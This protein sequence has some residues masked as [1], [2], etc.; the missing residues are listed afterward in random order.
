M[1]RL[2]QPS[3]SQ[4]YIKLKILYISIVFI[5]I[6]FQ[7]KNLQQTFSKSSE[8]I[9][10]K[11]KVGREAGNWPMKLLVVRS[12]I[13]K[14]L[15]PEKSGKVPEREFVVRLRDWRFLQFMRSGGRIPYKSLKPI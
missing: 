15:S 6:S 10:K 7:G 8:S 3:P 4:L 9:T 11:K 5:S 1:G 14:D 13:F 12:S 2:T